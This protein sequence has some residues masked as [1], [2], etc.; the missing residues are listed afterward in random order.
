MEVKVKYSEMFSS[1]FEEA[2]NKTPIAYL[3]LGTLEWHG[4]HLP[5][6]TDLIESEKLMLEIAQRCGGIVLPPLFLGPDRYKMDEKNGLIGMDYAKNTS[7]NKQLIGSSYWVSNGTFILIIDSILA[8]LKRAGFKAVF[9]DGHGP[10]RRSWAENLQERENRFGL[11]LFGVTDDIKEAWTYQ[12]DHAAKNETSIMMNIDDNLVK[13]NLLNKSFIGVNGNSLLLSSKEYG[14]ECLENSIRLIENKINLFKN[15]LDSNQTIIGLGYQVEH[16]S[17]VA[18]FQNEHLFSVAEERLSRIKKDKT[19]PI[20]GLNLINSKIESR[21][22]AP[23]ITCSFNSIEQYEAIY[24]KPEFLPKKEL[25]KL[26]QN[27]K[28]LQDLGANFFAGHHHSHAC[29]A[30]FTSGLEEATVLTYDGGISCEPWLASISKGDKGKLDT[31]KNFS[32]NDGAAIAIRYQAITMLLG[33]KP[34]EE[35]GKV[36]GLSAHGQVK[37][38]CVSALRIA[39]E[40]CN[41]DPDYYW[42]GQFG[43]DNSN[44]LELFSN[45]DIAAAIQNITEVDTTKF[46]KDNIINIRETNLVLA[47]G[48]F[49]NVKL[50]KIIQELGFK[51]IYIYPAMGDDGLALG[52]IYAYLNSKGLSKVNSIKNVY[53]GNSYSEIE[54]VNSLFTYQDIKWERLT[55]VEE[56]IAKLLAQGKVIGR[57]N[58]AMEFGPRSLG[59]RS[60]LCTAENHSI[61]E[62]L[63]TKLNR[64]EFMPFAPVTLKE[65]ASEMY[66]NLNGIENCTKYM[67]ICVD[68]TDRMK[69]ISPAVVH[70]DGTAR[71]QLIDEETNRSYYNIL[72]EYYKITG[73]P[74]LINT[75]FNMH[76]EPIVCSPDDAIRS[77]INGGLDYLAIGNFLVERV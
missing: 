72:R 66:V 5:L 77:F 71:P 30:Y 1:E 2:I 13:H 73:I 68:C 25:K 69:E 33:F 58:E 53:L 39:F 55:N 44:I 47:G 61:N 20:L 56:E 54:I 45:Q 38:E 7:P 16:D 11:K 64:T 15:S 52:A 59:N 6:G 29:G 36:T 62:V 21:V 35:E 26:K 40:K 24:N 49:A 63:N 31:V 3:P 10:S 8:Q 27:V 60:I 14:K 51:S 70:I 65:F 57:F 12:I 42:F 43:K 34:S 41:D 32:L 19:P 9:A 28:Q 46:I 74:N 22:D 23:I 48:L 50:N 18:L 76:G 37:E 17:N 75:S 67:T 4:E